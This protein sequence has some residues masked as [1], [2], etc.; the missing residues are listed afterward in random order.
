MFSTFP[1]PARSREAWEAL[2]TNKEEKQAIMM[3]K[4]SRGG[5]PEFISRVYKDHAPKN[6]HFH[7]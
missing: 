4:Y 2:A 7:E 5:W 3:E 6:L 1:Y